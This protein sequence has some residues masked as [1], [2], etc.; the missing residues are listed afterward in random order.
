MQRN[1]D[2]LNLISFKLHL[3]VFDFEL[4]RVF[5]SFIFFSLLFSFF[6]FFLF[7]LPFLNVS[8]QSS[9][10][11]RSIHYHIRVCVPSSIH[12]SIHPSNFIRI[13]PT[14][15][16][17]PSPSHPHTYLSIYTFI[18]SHHTTLICPSV[19]LVHLSSESRPRPRPRS[20]LLCIFPLPHWVFLVFVFNVP[21]TLAVFITST[22]YFPPLLTPTSNLQ[23]LVSNLQLP[24]S[25]LLPPTSSLQPPTFN[26][27]PPSPFPLFSSFFSLLL[28]V[29]YASTLLYRKQPSCMTYL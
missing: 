26:L 29:P 5:F 28:C 20:C 24:T 10:T 16:L 21:S 4:C 22:L 6:V 1:E 7:L 11:V 12:P 18:T 8:R 9:S 15:F 17:S 3:L 25:N 19:R 14:H 23:P 2:I 27:I 13:R